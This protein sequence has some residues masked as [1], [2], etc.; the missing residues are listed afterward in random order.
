MR[1]EKGELIHKVLSHALAGE[2]ISAKALTFLSDLCGKI[3]DIEL[4]EFLDRWKKHFNW[5]DIPDDQFN[6]VDG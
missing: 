5:Q 1:D 4:L 3:T 6:D 2:K